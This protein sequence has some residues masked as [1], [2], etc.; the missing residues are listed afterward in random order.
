MQ[1]FTD[2]S[3]NGN[4]SDGPPGPPAALF[5]TQVSR[6]CTFVPEPGW[7]PYSAF[8]PT[9]PASVYSA[10]AVIY[11]AAVGVNP[12]DTTFGPIGVGAQ[13]GNIAVP[14]LVI[15]PQVGTSSFA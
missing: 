14:A 9:H 5:A 8:N 1:A 10:P 7:N 6:V 3:L 4:F 11:T 15:A 13:H 2:V 12:Y